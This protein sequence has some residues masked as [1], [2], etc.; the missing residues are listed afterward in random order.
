MARIIK[1]PNV[2]LEKPFNVVDRV[3]TLLHAEEEAALIIRAAQEREESI[4][5][6]ASQ[7]ADGIAESAKTEADEIIAQAKIDGEAIKEEAR[8]QGFEDGLKQGREEAVKQA[9]GVIQNLRSMVV[10]GKAILEAMFRDQEPVI[11]KLVCDIV[12]RV[13]RKT[14]EEDNDTVVRV[15]SDAI[16]LA[17]D[18][19]TL[20]VLVH[21]DDREKIEEWV[22]EFTRLFDEIDSISIEADTRVNRGG[23]IIESGTGGVD[24]R[25]EKQVEILNDAVLNS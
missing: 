18:R 20:Q 11:R 7:Q 4:L 17:A 6:N 15:T 21:P 24:A 3:E 13:V 19:Q 5:T 1:A 9:A 10:E 16:K 2:R 8:K 14:I 12:S 22:P 23:V 25:I